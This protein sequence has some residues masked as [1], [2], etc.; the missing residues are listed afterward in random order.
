MTRLKRKLFEMSVCLSFWDSVCLWPAFQRFQ[1]LLKIRTGRLYCLMTKK[2]HKNVHHLC[3]AAYIFTKHLQNVCPINTHILIYQYVGCDCKLWTNFSFCCM[4]LTIFTH[5]CRLFMP[6]VLYFYQIFTD[7]ISNQ[8][9][10]F[11]IFTN[12]IQLHV[13][14][15]F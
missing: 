11:A 15:C 8:Y 13:M 4:F 6:E 1:K 7:C 2:Y 10:H 3:L 5:N 12:Q 14:K 9:T